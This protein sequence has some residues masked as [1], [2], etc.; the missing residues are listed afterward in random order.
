MKVSLGSNSKYIEFDTNFESKGGVYEMVYNGKM[1]TQM[2]QKL[3]FILLKDTLDVMGSDLTTLETIINDYFIIKKVD[4]KS[5]LEFDL[6]MV[7]LTLN[8]F[9]AY[10]ENQRK[11]NKKK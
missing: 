3:K 5:E 2:Y 6:T 8:S 1:T 7:I 10:V 11:E 4:K 9:I